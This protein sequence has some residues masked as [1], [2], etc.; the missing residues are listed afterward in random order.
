MTSFLTKQPSRLNSHYLWSTV[1]SAARTLSTIGAL[2]LLIVC[3]TALAQPARRRVP[4]TAPTQGVTSGAQPTLDRQ[5]FENSL[6][7]AVSPKVMGYTFLLIKDGRVAAEGAGGLARNSADGQMKMTTRTPQNLGSLFKFITG[8]TMLHLL[9][10]APAGSA[11]GNNSFQTRLGAPVALL[12]PQLWNAGVKTPAIR[13]ITF[14]QLL[15][16]RS[17]FRGCSTPLG[18]F[19]GSYDPTLL[20]KRDYQNINFSLLGYLIPLYATPNLLPALNGV[21]KTVPAAERDANM[22]VVLGERM[23]RFMREKMFPLAPGNISASCDAA[24]EYKSTGAYGYV[25]KTDTGKGIITSRKADNKP[26]SGAGGNWMSI[27]DFGAFVAAAL[28]SD[29]M[30]S[31]QARLEMYRTGM[32]PDDRLVWSFTTT[33]PWIADRFKMPTI[34]W[35]NGVQRYDGQSFNTVLLRLPLNYELMIFVNS[36]GMGVDSLAGAGFK[37]F[38]AGMEP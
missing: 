18:C 15:Q 34:L 7:A 16:H 13:T 30:L 8:V 24:N 27:R 12:Y 1:A 10:R 22:Q 32:A 6:H 36:G 31:Q 33:D 17:G 38:R 21:P 29:R 26:C 5:A 4:P 37:A 3:T 9:D 20:G 2:L 14:R 28:H 23:D 11:G 35:S 19:G 25:S